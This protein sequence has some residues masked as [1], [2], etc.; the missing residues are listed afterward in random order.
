VKSKVPWIGGDE[1]SASLSGFSIDTPVPS[2]AGAI[3][4][5]FGSMWEWVKSKVSWLGSSISKAIGFSLDVPIPEI[6]G[7]VVGAFT[8]MWEA[9]KP[10]A[11]WLVDTYTQAVKLELKAAAA[12]GG[13]IVD[14]FPSMWDADPWLSGKTRSGATATS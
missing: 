14:Q 4:G 7:A 9:V 13:A 2:V 5:A 1:I 8:S 12:I 10:V 3:V 11:S 6:G